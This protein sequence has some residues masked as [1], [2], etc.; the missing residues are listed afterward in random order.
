[1]PFEKDVQLMQPILPSAS[2]IAISGIRDF[3]AD[4]ATLVEKTVAQLLSTSRTELRFGGA[5][6][7]DTVALVTAGRLAVPNVLLTVIVPSTVSQQPVDAQEVIQK[8]AHKVV[9]MKLVLSDK[10]SYQQRNV[11]LI[12]EADGLL[13]FWHGK[14]GG[15]ANCINAA[16]QIGLPVEVVWLKGL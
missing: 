13:A 1:M 10:R 2:R 4:D 7:T 11:A 14:P 3:T 16:R 5:R 12:A 15:T 9:E 8:Y 6:G